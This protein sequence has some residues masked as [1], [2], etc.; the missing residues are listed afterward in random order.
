MLDERVAFR[1]GEFV[2]WDDLTVHIMSHSFGR[3]SAIFEVLSF[4]DMPTGLSVFRLDRHIQRLSRSAG[5]LHMELPMSEEVLHRTVLDTVARNGLRQGF[6]KIF[7]YYP[8]IAA[9]ILPPQG[10]LDL[11][12]VV[13]DP[14]QDMGI[15]KTPIEQG[16]T[17]CVSSWRK[18]DPQTVPV[19]AKVAA[20]YLNGMVARLEAQ[21]RGFESV[22][23]LDAD[24][25]IAEG[26][27]ESVF[28]A[29][30]GV[31]MTPLLGSVLRSI[32]RESVLEVAG[33]IGLEISEGKF[34]ADHLEEA[35][36]IFF[37]STGVKVQPVSRIGE[38]VL[39]GTPGPLTKKV[40]DF[41]NEIVEGR[42]ER[43]QHWLF[44]VPA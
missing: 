20:N 5:L 21:T 14:V 1:N 32:T 24:G 37:S 36:E 12:I 7:A 40:A 19:E 13:F 42:E 27:T 9:K 38:R 8:Q 6:I 30:D 39:E 34:D 15:P 35:D 16:T 25:F 4:H 41:F 22:I 23:M 28:F 11:S 10:R 2:P 17:A 31:L 3:G 26:S 44:P 29:K 33:V 18:L 43:F